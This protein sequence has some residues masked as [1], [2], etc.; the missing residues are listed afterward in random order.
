MFRI[1]SLV[2]WKSDDIPASLYCEQYAKI[3]EY[4]K[5]HPSL[6]GSTFDEVRALKLSYLET[7]ESDV[8]INKDIYKKKKLWL[9][10]CIKIM[11]LSLIIY[12]INIIS[13]KQIKYMCENK[14]IKPSLETPIDGSRER[15][16][17]Y[18]SLPKYSSDSTVESCMEK[19]NIIVENIS[20]STNQLSEN[21][22]KKFYK[23]V[24]LK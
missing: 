8:S 12:S 20:D 14:E 1:I 24:F 4:G 17:T 19:K 11:F 9:N 16:I 18:D 23:L 10:N 22:L 15:L 5:T 2:K 3:L 13:Y 6:D 21:Y 7:L